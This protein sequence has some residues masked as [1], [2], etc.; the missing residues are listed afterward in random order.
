MHPDIVAITYNDTGHRH[1]E[2]DI[3]LWSWQVQAW[4]DIFSASLDASKDFY[5]ASHVHI[6]M[7]VDGEEAVPYKPYAN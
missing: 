5:L 1:L 7:Y 4:T 6:V 3:S 2:R